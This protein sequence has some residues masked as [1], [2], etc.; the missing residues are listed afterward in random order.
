MRGVLATIHNGTIIY[1]AGNETEVNFDAGQRNFTFNATGFNNVWLHFTADPSYTGQPLFT[2]LVGLRP[3]NKTDEFKEY[4][5]KVDEEEE[6]KIEIPEPKI[7][8]PPTRNDL[9]FNERIVIYCIL[10]SIVLFCCKK[11]YCPSSWMIRT[12][13]EEELKQKIEMQR[14]ENL[15]SDSDEEFEKDTKQASDGF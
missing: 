14:I 8:I 6:R 2:A 9:T 13:T 5:K 15:P 10:F 11:N 7:I 1:A 4:D 12:P 3:T